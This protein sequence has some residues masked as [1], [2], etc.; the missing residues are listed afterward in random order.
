MLIMFI[1]TMTGWNGCSKSVLENKKES[2]STDTKS[3]NGWKLIQSK[4]DRFIYALTTSHI[5]KDYLQS[6]RVGSLET[7]S[8]RS[9][10][11]HLKRPKP[12][13]GYD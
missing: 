3:V 11:L 5:S 8:R 10:F 1:R 6:S 4:S 9:D 12:T 2:L 13:A 7:V